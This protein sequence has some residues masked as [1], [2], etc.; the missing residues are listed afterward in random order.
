MD[1]NAD[2][3]Q[4]KILDAAIKLFTHYGY[5]KTTIAELAADCDMSA[6]NIYRYFESKLDIAERIAERESVEIFSKLKSIAHCGQRGCYERL[7]DFLFHELRSTFHLLENSPKIAHMVSVLS[8][9]RPAFINQQLHKQR[10][11]LE[12]ILESSS[13]AE[14]IK[15]K[16]SNFIA[17]MIQSATMK[18][19]YPQ[20]FSHLTLEQLETELKGVIHLLFHGICHTPDAKAAQDSKDSPPKEPVSH[21]V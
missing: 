11:L 3:Q 6:G 7:R 20:L 12:K 2:M 8:E 5:D 14:Q 9:K 15:E 21:G 17:E 10:E 19:R 1:S 13:F 16:N 18:F 4:K